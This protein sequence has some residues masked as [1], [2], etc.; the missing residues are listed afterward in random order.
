M[1]TTVVDAN[2]PYTI[3]NYREDQPGV[4]KLLCALKVVDLSL[5]LKKDFEKGDNL[6]HANLVVVGERLEDMP[7]V[8]KIGDIIRIQK[9]SLK[10]REGQR[11]FIV[12]ERSSWCLFSP[13]T[14][15]SDEKSKVS[16]GSDQFGKLSNV[17]L[18]DMEFEDEQDKEDPNFK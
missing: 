5:Y 14:T 4:K 2:Y 17:L 18:E 12:D 11:Q 7:I 10:M 13:N 1:Y 3:K 9:A 16:Y 6:Q 15:G 8:R